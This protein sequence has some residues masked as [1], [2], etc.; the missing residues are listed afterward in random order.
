MCLHACSAQH[1][2]QMSTTADMKPRELNR[3]GSEFNS[4]YINNQSYQ[5]A[6]LAAGGCFNAVEKILSGEVRSPHASRSSQLPLSL[7][8]HNHSLLARPSLTHQ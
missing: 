6:L 1:I 4:I 7:S 5:S 3:L 2:Q 8:T